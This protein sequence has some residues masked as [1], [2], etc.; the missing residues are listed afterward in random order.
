MKN[1][2]NK[3]YPTIYCRVTNKVNSKYTILFCG[4]F[5]LH[6]RD[7]TLAQHCHFVSTNCVISIWFNNNISLNFFLFVRQ[8]LKS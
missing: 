5:V 7:W 2:N 1:R 6:N 8:G 3:K 4:A